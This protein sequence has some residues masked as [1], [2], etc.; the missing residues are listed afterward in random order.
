MEN[1]IAETLKESSR[2]RIGVSRQQLR[3]RTTGPCKKASRKPFQENKTLNGLK[4][5]ASISKEEKMDSSRARMTRPPVIN[6]YPYEL[7]N[8]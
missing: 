2:Q 5:S 1:K 6:S 3:R 8:L 4:S 7:K